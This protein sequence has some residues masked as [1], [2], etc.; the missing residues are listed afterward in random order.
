[1][2]FGTACAGTVG[3]EVTTGKA[4]LGLNNQRV[5]AHERYAVLSEAAQVRNQ[6]AQK[7][8]GQSCAVQSPNSRR[9]TVKRVTRQ[10]VHD[11]L[12]DR[13][14]DESLREGEGYFY[15]GG[16]EAVNWLSNTVRVRKLSELTLV[17]WLAEFD[18]LVETN[19][20][21]ERSMV[22]AK[23]KSKG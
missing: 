19:K 12:R 14:R 10:M 6:S 18:K 1:M 22:P 21:L 13:G 2:S 5:S 15:F 3:I 11:A 4:R 17:Q 16:E 23:K 8:K 7:F 9:E 20:K